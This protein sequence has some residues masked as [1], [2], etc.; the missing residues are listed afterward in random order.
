MSLFQKDMQV[1]LLL[2]FYGD[3]L[4]ERRR[5]VTGLYYNDDLSLAEIAEITGISRQGVRDAVRRSVDELHSLEDKLGLVKRFSVLRDEI[6]II[7]KEL[8]SL[9]SD[10]PDTS[11][12]ERLKGIAKKLSELN[13]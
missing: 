12:S 4:S 13:I 8:D 2:D 1:S 11:L 9:A 3:T 10:S 5:E 7:T 6:D